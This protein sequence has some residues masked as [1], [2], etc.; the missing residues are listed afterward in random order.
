MPC[1]NLLSEWIQ[2]ILAQDTFWCL[3]IWPK[4]RQ[5]REIMGGTNYQIIKFGTGV[6]QREAGLPVTFLWKAH[7]VHLPYDQFC[8]TLIVSF[9]SN[10]WPFPPLAVIIHTYIQI[11]TDIF[12]LPGERMDSWQFSVASAQFNERKAFQ[13]AR[14]LECFF[15][16]RNMGS[17]GIHHC[18]NSTTSCYLSL[19]PGSC[20]QKTVQWQVLNKCGW[21]HFG[22]G[23]LPVQL[24]G[25]RGA[26]KS[27]GL[28]KAMVHSEVTVLSQTMR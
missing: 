22:N 20:F 6:P 25:M 9:H 10:T 21:Q 24:Q 7:F 16:K 23:P 8:Y 14:E 27:S 5:Q 26:G 13:T 3:K 15:K 19:Q 2:T 1:R 28:G 4:S 18:V 11:Y 12:S 17:R